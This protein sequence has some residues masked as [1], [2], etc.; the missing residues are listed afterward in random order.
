M[1]GPEFLLDT[2]VVI[3]QLDGRVEARDILEKTGAVPDRSAVSQI[4]RMEL[5]RS[6]GIT[7]VHETRVL[8]F[9]NSVEVLLFDTAVETRAIALRRAHRLKL[10]DAIVAATAD[11][12]GLQLVTL[13]DRL[14]RVLP[15][16][17]GP[18]P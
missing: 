12:H 3:G 13:D 16:G 7:P 4:T 17:S 14:A 15:A 11:V 10:P 2:N 1:S 8:D 5:L 9:L 6:P 18:S